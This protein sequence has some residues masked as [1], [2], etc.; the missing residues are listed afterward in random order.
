LIPING[1]PAKRTVQRT[2]LPPGCKYGCQNY[3]KFCLACYSLNFRDARG[4][5]ARHSNFGEILGRSIKGRH[6]HNRVAWLTFR[7]FYLDVMIER[8]PRAVALGILERQTKFPRWAVATTDCDKQ[9]IRSRPN[10]R[11]HHFAENIRHTIGRTLN[12]CAI[13]VRHRHA[14][15]CIAG[16]F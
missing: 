8:L 9:S 5:R 11:L 6:Q 10:V 13:I 2:I 15:D 1:K 12:Q 4:A 3:R 14:E 16:R 7:H